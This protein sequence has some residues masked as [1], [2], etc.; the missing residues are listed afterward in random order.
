MLALN[1][2]DWA[3]NYGLLPGGE[4]KN[5]LEF[6]GVNE[7]ISFMK[8][9][10]VL[11]YKWSKGMYRKLSPQAKLGLEWLI[12]EDNRRVGPV[13]WERIRVNDNVAALEPTIITP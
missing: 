8:G 1:V 5:E 4:H 7:L 2:E 13:E 10:L 6:S 3:G 9:D 11:Q 12:N